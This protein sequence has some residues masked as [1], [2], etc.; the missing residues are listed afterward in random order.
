MQSI[1]NK[2]QTNHKGCHLCCLCLRISSYVAKFAADGG[3]SSEYL[4]FSNEC[5]I[6]VYICIYVMM[7]IYNVYIENM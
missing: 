7:Y 6:D 1:I 5:E 4:Q 2:F 3:S